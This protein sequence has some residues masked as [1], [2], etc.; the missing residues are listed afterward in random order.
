MVLQIP[1]IVV[2]LKKYSY[3]RVSGSN[4]KHNVIVV[5]NGG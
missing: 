1:L 3:Q 4:L 2:T 5:M